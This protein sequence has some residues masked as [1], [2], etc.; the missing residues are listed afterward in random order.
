MDDIQ[1]QKTW[2]IF[3]KTGSV[4]AYLKYKQAENEYIS[5]KEKET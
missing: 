2:D 1:I 3:E 5:K 4:N